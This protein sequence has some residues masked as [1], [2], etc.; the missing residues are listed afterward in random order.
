MSNEELEFEINL[1]IELRGEKSTF[2]YTK[3]QDILLAQVEK[4]CLTLYDVDEWPINYPIGMIAIKASEKEKK[5][6]IKVDDKLHSF[7]FRLRD[8]VQ[9]TVVV[10]TNDWFDIAV[11]VSYILGSKKIAV[12]ILKTQA[13]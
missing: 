7:L 13:K 11:L 9:K 4:N 10:K 2:I 1:E 12:D 5:L 6:D 3:E 8:K